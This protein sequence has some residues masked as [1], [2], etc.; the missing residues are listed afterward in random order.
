[1]TLEKS[2]NLFWYTDVLIY[3]IGI[4]PSSSQHWRGMKQCV[5][6]WGYNKDSVPAL[7]NY[8]RILTMI[9]GVIETMTHYK[10]NIY[11]ISSVL[12]TRI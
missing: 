7:K 8:R 5:Q 11:P 6:Y 12:T 1:M 2:L 10:F 3:S 4:T 9:T